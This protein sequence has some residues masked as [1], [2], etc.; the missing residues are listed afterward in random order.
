MAPAVVC[1]NQNNKRYGKVPS[2]LWNFAY[3]PRLESER[4]FF[5]YMVGKKII[6]VK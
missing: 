5:G 3:F 1:A 4:I 6:N 2:K